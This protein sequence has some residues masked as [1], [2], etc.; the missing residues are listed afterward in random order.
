MVSFVLYLVV[1]S[2]EGPMKARIRNIFLAL[3]AV[4]LAF[5]AGAALAGYDEIKNR[6]LVWKTGCKGDFCYVSV[7]VAVNTRATG[8]AGPIFDLLVG[9]LNPTT[10]AVEVFET[11]AS[12]AGLSQEQGRRLHKAYRSSRAGVMKYLAGGRDSIQ[13]NVA[14]PPGYSICDVRW[15]VH[16]TD[17]TGSLTIAKAARSATFTATVKIS[18]SSSHQLQGMIEVEFVKAVRLQALR[19]KDRCFAANSLK[20][21]LAKRAPR[22]GALRRGRYLP[23]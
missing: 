4:F 8:L 13:F 1:H 18:P 15:N 22:M 10:C 5:H 17:N 14:A 23:L 19:D 21:Y 9:C 7:P 2:I 3:G 12:E 20:A 6:G 16:T 11:G